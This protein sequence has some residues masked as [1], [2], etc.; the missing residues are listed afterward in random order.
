M[1][2]SPIPDVDLRKPAAGFLTKWS[3]AS[4]MRS[5]TVFPFVLWIC[6]HIFCWGMSKVPLVAGVAA[7][8][9]SVFT[10]ICF[11]LPYT[12]EALGNCPGGDIVCYLRTLQYGQPCSLESELVAGEWPAGTHLCQRSHLSTAQWVKDHPMWTPGFNYTA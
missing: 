7:F 4:L 10:A 12:L 6:I 8:Y 5:L 3:Q 11:N 9:N 1:Q 2:A